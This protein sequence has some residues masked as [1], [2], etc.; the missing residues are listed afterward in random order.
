MIFPSEA[1]FEEA[2]IKVLR[3]KGSGDGWGSGGDIC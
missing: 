1:E 3:D 2:L